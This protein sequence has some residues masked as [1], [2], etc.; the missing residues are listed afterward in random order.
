M[1][2]GLS[3]IQTAAE[4]FVYMYRCRFCGLFLEIILLPER[5]I[6]AGEISTSTEKQVQPATP[7]VIS[8]VPRLNASEKNDVLN[9]YQLTCVSVWKHEFLD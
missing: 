2:S 8:Q 5:F 9:W 4:E 7:R 6:E 3:V 1:V